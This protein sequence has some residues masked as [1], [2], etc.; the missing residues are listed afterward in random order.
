M[1]TITKCTC[2]IYGVTIAPRRA[3]ALQVPTPIDLNGVGYTY[4][5]KNYITQNCL[6]F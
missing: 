6:I 1:L 3:I 4:K 5:Y 2:A